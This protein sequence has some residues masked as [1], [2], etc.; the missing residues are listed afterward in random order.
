MLNITNYQEDLKQKHNEISPHTCQNGYYQKQTNNGDWGGW[1]KG[2]CWWEC[3]QY[4]GSLKFKIS[5]TV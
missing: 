1:G 2:N 5:S 3:K 4:G